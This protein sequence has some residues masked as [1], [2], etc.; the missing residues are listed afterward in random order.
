MLHPLL[1]KKKKKEE[2]EEIKEEKYL[3]SIFCPSLIQ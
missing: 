2:E 1:I 3:V